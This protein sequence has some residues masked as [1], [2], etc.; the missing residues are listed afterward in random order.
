MDS[1]T[2]LTLFSF[3]FLA[4][5]EETSCPDGKFSLSTTICEQTESSAIK[6]LNRE[7]LLNI[8]V[9]YNN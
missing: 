2:H 6:T 1:Q 9:F 7:D 5:A 3:I 4:G 8:K